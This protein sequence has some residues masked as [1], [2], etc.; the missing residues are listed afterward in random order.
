MEIPGGARV[1]PDVSPHNSPRGSDGHVS[2]P[3]QSDAESA[4]DYEELAARAV[5]RDSDSGSDLVID[6]FPAAPPP[7]PLARTLF[8]ELAAIPHARSHVVNIPP[9][10]DESATDDPSATTADS[11]ASTPAAASAAKSDPHW[12][13]FPTYTFRGKQVPRNNSLTPPRINEILG[14]WGWGNGLGFGR[15]LLA[16]R[17]A[18]DAAGADPRAAGA[19]GVIA[20]VVH[21]FGYWALLAMAATQ[22]KG[23]NVAYNDALKP[24][25]DPAKRAAHLQFEDAATKYRQ[26]L[27]L[28]SWC[29]LTLQQ[30]G[31][32]SNPD[33]ASESRDTRP[34][35]SKQAQEAVNLFK[36]A[37]VHDC[38]LGS[39]DLAQIGRLSPE[40]LR[41]RIGELKAQAQQ[42]LETRMAPASD[43]AA[44]QRDYQVALAPLTDNGSQRSERDWIQYREMTGVIVALFGGVDSLLTACGVSPALT[45]NWKGVLATLSVGAAALT[46]LQQYKIGSGV[47]GSATLAKSVA[48][49]STADMHQALPRAQHM[50]STMDE[51]PGAPAAAIK[52][53]TLSILLGAIDSH[54]KDLAAGVVSVAGKKHT[55]GK[56][57]KIGATLANLSTVLAQLVKAFADKDDKGAQ[58]F[59]LLCSSLAIVAGMCL[60]MFYGRWVFADFASIMQTAM[61]KNHRFTAEAKAMRAEIEAGRAECFGGPSMQMANGN[62]QHAI[63]LLACALRDATP[64]QR[65]ALESY[66]AGIESA[67]SYAEHFGMPR[68]ELTRLSAQATGLAAQRDTVSRLP[69]P[70]PLSREQS[71]A[72]VT[73]LVRRQETLGLVDPANTLASL[74]NIALISPENVTSYL[75]HQVLA[76]HI[77]EVKLASLTGVGAREAAQHMI[78]LIDQNIRALAL[79]SMAVNVE[80]PAAQLLVSMANGAANQAETVHAALGID[81]AELNRLGGAMW[82]EYVEFAQHPELALTTGYIN[83]ATQLV[84]FIQRKVSAT[85]NDVLGQQFMARK[86]AW[87]EAISLVIGTAAASRAERPVDPTNPYQHQHELALH[88]AVVLLHKVAADLIEA[89]VLP[90]IEDALVET[91]PEL[92]TYLTNEAQRAAHADAKAALEHNMNRLVGDLSH[93]L[94]LTKGYG[95]N[96]VYE[97]D[98]GISMATRASAPEAASGTVRSRLQRAETTVATG[99]E[100]KE[101][102]GF[103]GFFGA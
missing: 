18:M 79:R 53:Q 76:K 77:E 97:D 37:L 2:E 12:L 84:D 30:S 94:I 29:E 67:Q 35:L 91:V 72:L 14:S 31:R 22:K 16:L 98:D 61:D 42:I 101:R 49:R 56:T 57:L 83:A 88:S 81:G 65:V 20:N 75:Q 103:G 71:A 82:S 17:L 4:L 33:V 28:A 92:N 66:L 86:Q 85:G 15:L 11:A 100:R 99:I 9:P 78:E 60:A 24:R 19:M 44:D 40:Q 7:V 48:S 69:N 45:E 54:I 89:S 47:M 36:E 70:L 96:P 13:L 80:N 6:Y 8:E 73:A 27:G 39:R 38:E 90:A 55:L 10:S 87:I 64:L 3:S 68:G 52:S 102:K 93:Y 46:G 1:S 74:E 62:P 58:S 63:Y 41:A 21:G 95:L 51:V 26:A 34:A 50:L 43:R 5:L 23:I 25:S 59:S 32:P